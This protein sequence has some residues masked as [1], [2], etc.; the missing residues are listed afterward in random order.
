MKKESLQVR[1]VAYR[2]HIVALVF[3]FLIY[4]GELK[5]QSHKVI[6]G[7]VGGFRGLIKTE[8]IDAK[9]LTHVNYAFVD[10]RNNRAWLHREATDTINFRHLNLLKKQNPALKILI[11]IE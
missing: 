6:I 2:L 4:G 3:C 7:Y 11:S 8:L 10:V 9:K 5:A 1:A